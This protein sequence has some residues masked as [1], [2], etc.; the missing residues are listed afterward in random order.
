MLYNCT[1]FLQAAVIGNLCHSF[2]SFNTCYKDT[3]LWGMYFVCEPLKIDVRLFAFKGG[4]WKA[5]V[6]IDSWC[7]SVYG[8]VVVYLFTSFPFFLW[9][10]GGFVIFF[11]FLHRNGFVW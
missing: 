7:R 10:N 5:G 6:W 2:Q 1:F 8:V 9:F 4:G 11:V 3:G